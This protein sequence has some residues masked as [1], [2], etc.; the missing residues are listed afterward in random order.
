MNLRECQFF[1]LEHSC[2]K[3]E[4]DK[5]YFLVATMTLRSWNIC[6]SGRERLINIPQTIGLG[7]QP[8]GED[9]FLRKDPWPPTDKGS[10]GHFIP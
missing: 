7:N 10:P 8:A 5:M 3:D 9:T 4:Q 6:S 1:N 2:L